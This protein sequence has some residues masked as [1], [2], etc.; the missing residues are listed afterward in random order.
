MADIVTQHFV[1]QAARDELYAADIQQLV[2][3]L[4]AWLQVAQDRLE[5]SNRY[6]HDDQVGMREQVVHVVGCM[7]IR[8]PGGGIPA[9]PGMAA[10]PQQGGQCRAEAAVAEEAYSMDWLHRGPSRRK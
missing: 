1:H 2:P 3:A 10:L 9:T 6:R 8:Q 5:G 4:Q 7:G